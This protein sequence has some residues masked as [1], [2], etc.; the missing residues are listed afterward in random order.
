MKP[1]L[2]PA[3]LAKLADLA[4]TDNTRYA[5]TGV[6]LEIADADRR[7]LRAVAT[8][9]KVLGMVEW[10]GDD[11][12]NYP[13]LPGLSAAPNGATDA[14]I[15]TT[16]WKTLAAPGK[17][18][19]FKPVLR[20][21]AAV[22]GPNVVTFGQT[23][24]DTQNVQEHRQVE[25]RFPPYREIMP[26]GK[27]V[28]RLCVDPVLLARVLTTANA[29]ACDDEHRRVEL[30]F[31]DDSRPF[32]VRGHAGN[33]QFTGLV[34]PLS[35]EDAKD[36]QKAH[37]LADERFARK[38]WEP[39]PTK[40]AAPSEPAPDDPPPNP[41]P[42]PPALAAFRAAKERHPG[43]IVLFRI[44]DFFEAFTEDAEI[45]SKVLGLTLTQRDRQ[46]PM[47]GFPHHQLEG[48]LKKLLHAGHRVAVCDQDEPVERVVGPA[49]GPSDA[50][51]PDD[52]PRDFTTQPPAA[53]GAYAQAE[54]ST[55]DAQLVD[56]GRRWEAGESIKQL[57][58]ERGVSWNRLYADLKK[59]GYQPPTRRAAA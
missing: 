39:E 31:Y 28:L 11:P 6:R 30:L 12:A 46:V 59:A 29:M 3:R 38:P 2:I 43:M 24:L 20:N 50:P 42:E 14:L 44:G 25:G 26:K 54:G 41:D 55:Y 45:V 22:L 10:Q 8:D 48:Y 49:N 40:D 47:A 16:A 9:S 17:F 53:P 23:N 57:A 35:Y 7:G 37:A 33:V 52:S 36:K 56:A 1:M 5:L 34:M 18:K 15:P 19:C 13:D 21:T 4:A 51:R 32:L 27:P 58:A